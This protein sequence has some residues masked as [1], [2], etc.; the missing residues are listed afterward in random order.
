MSF[1]RLLTPF[2][3]ISLSLVLVSVYLL[4]GSVAQAQVSEGQQDIGA[5]YEQAMKAGQTH[6]ERGQT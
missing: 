1:L 2:S 4:S 5:E 3:T 6:L